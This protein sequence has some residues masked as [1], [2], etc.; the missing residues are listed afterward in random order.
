MKKLLVMLLTLVLVAGAVVLSVSAEAEPRRADCPDCQ[1][2]VEWQPITVSNIADICD[3]TDIINGH[4]YLYEDLK[5]FTY[6]TI[7]ENETVCLD[8][9]GKTITSTGRSFRVNKAKSVLNIMDSKTGGTIISK[10]AASNVHGGTITSSTGGTVNLYSGT[11]RYISTENSATTR[12]GVIN[13]NGGNMNIYGGTVD[14]GQCTLV[15]KS[16]TEGGAAI[17]MNANTTLNIS[18]GQIIAGNKAQGGAADCVLVGA[19]TAV[20][21]LSG[22]AKV[23]ELYFAY[24][25]ASSLVVDGAYTGT[26][27]LAYAPTVTVKEGNKIGTLVNNG[28]VSGADISFDN[29]RYGVAA[30]GTDLV[31]AIKPATS[32]DGWCEYCKE[33]V[34]WEPWTEDNTKTDNNVFTGHYYLYEDV[35]GCPVKIAKGTVC[36]DLNGHKLQSRGRSFVSSGQ[37]YTEGTPIINMMDSQGVGCVIGTDGSNNPTGG[38]VYLIDGGVFNLYGGTLKHITDGTKSATTQGGVVC[39]FVS[40]R[41]TV[42]GV[43]NLYGGSIDASE[44]TMKEGAL[45]QQFLLASGVYSMLTAVMFMPVRSPEM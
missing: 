36:I 41:A 16:D 37:S 27:K 13:I 12:G 8:L 21:T 17:A 23:D 33:N 1:K 44:C 26:A 10:S 20:V 11:L 38:T 3:G 15:Y 18:G 19:A 34:T 28:T 32:K 40:T 5:S 25:S 42:G 39:L 22:D 45:V 2:T 14:A 35:T 6:K 7:R 29:A 4:Y 30:S 31:M 43:L 24:T 9:N